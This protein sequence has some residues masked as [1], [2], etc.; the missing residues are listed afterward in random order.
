MTLSAKEAK[1]Q[2]F[3]A[4]YDIVVCGGGGA[5]AGCVVLALARQQSHS[6]G[7]AATLGGTSFNAA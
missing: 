7:K 6:P 4:E 3:D 5:G 1:A 2:T